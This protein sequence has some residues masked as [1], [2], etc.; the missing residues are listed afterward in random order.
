MQCPHTLS[1]FVLHLILEVSNKHVLEQN[2]SEVSIKRR[3]T[4]SART[5]VR[6]VN[7]FPAP[8]PPIPV[9]MKDR[10]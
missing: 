8:N 2:F 7:S 3:F 5:F 9:G 10:D 6:F 4:A 1:P